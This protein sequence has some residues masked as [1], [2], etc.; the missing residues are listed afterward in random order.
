MPMI[1]SSLSGHVARTR[2]ET[3]RDKAF[4]FGQLA[5]AIEVYT[6]QREAQRQG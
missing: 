6:R 1:Q 3:L 5:A 4:V 2:R